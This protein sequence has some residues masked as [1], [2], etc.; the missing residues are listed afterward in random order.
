MARVIGACGCI[1]SDCRMLEKECMGCHAIGGKA[2][3]LIIK[4]T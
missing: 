3:W 1:Y 4:I 2:C